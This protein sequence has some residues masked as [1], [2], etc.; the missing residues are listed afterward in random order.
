M[1]FSNF[2]RVLVLTLFLFLV[3]LMAVSQITVPN[4]YVGAQKGLAEKG[5]SEEQLKLKLAEK[6]IDIDNISPEDLPELEGTIQQAIEEIEAENG[7][8]T[9]NGVVEDLSVNNELSKE[10]L[11]QKFDD[12]DEIEIKEIETEIDE[13]Q[14][15]EEAISDFESEHNGA[16]ESNIYGH[17]LF[18]DESLD[19]YRTTK[20][21]GTPDYYILDVGDKITI[22][23]F[24]LSQADLIY[25]IEND[26]FIR[27]SG[28]YKIY[29]KGLNLVQAR[30]LLF[31][32]FQQAYSFKKG[33]FNL[34]VN[35]A[36][37]VSVSIY[38]EVQHPGTYTMSALNSTLNAI[39]AAGGPTKNG[40]VREIQLTS[41]SDKYEIDV[42]DFLSQPSSIINYGLRNNMVIFIPPSK[43]I[44]TLSG[45][46]LHTGKFEVKES[47]TLSDLISIAGGIKKG[48]VLKNFNMIRNNGLE[49]SLN[50]HDFEKSKD[51]VLED[52]DRISFMAVSR[53]YENYIKISGAIRYP[54]EY[55]FSE[56]VTLKSLLKEVQLEEFA[57]TDIGYLTRRNL[58]GTAQLI[59]FSLDPNSKDIT[60]QKQDEIFVFNQRSFVR[61]YTFSISGAVAHEKL[62]HYVDD[63]R[64]MRLSDAILLAGGL[65]DNAANFAYISRRSIENSKKLSYKIIPISDVLSNPESRWNISIAPYDNIRIPTTENFTEQQ[66]IEVKGAVR[67]PQKLVYDESLKLKD[68]LLRAGGLSFDASTNRIDIFRLEINENKPT[69]TLFSSV[70]INRDL[71]P[72]TEEDRITLKPFDIVVVRQVPD[73]DPIQ[74]VNITGEVMYPGQYAI[75]LGKERVSDLI[76]KA[77]GLTEDA[78]LGNSTLYRSEDGL[79]FVAVNFKKAI[80]KKSNHNL[81]LSEGDA[82]N[83]GKEISLVLINHQGTNADEFLI[84]E[85]KNDAIISAPYTSNKR[86]GY[87]IKKYN[88]GFA[89]EA[90]PSKTF[91]KNPDG[92]LLKAHNFLLFRVHRKVKKGS[93]II[94]GMKDVQDTQNKSRRR[95]EKSKINLKDAAM[96][97]M[98]VVVSAF[99]VITMAQNLQ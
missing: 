38:G 64:K 36:R 91:V 75:T 79:G 61:N 39:I 73:F 66:F 4:S 98:S 68:L 11:D 59:S 29:L 41:G 8:K 5:I 40:S 31:K 56:G 18:F 80:K 1:S 28:M 10:D 45:P 85:L 99:T 23:I 50:T 89:K 35:T 55:E 3:N 82:I 84:D 46:F 48:M 60:L 25:Q 6:G 16:N 57:R 20:T 76:A 21:S 67:N 92:R 42:Y 47:E 27:P 7:Q 69:R 94:V 9:G 78:Y 30:K 93:E 83:I 74:L 43:Q 14:S 52:L 95:T 51:I 90:K 26:G 72:S 97:L 12:L 86:A 15:I 54:G 71:N 58:D 77:G 63:N 44:V 32:R 33:E 65:Q 62:D 87:Y 53:V 2:Q 37:T 13:G 81:I 22:N 70:S 96:E 19:F 24:G 49:D 88:G 17:D 34:D